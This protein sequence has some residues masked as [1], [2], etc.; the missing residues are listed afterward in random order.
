MFPA[1]TN[2]DLSHNKLRSIPGTISLLSYLSVLNVTANSELDLLPPELGL[3]DKLWNVGLRECPLRKEEEPLRSMVNDKRES[4]KTIE[5][6][7]Y[8]R[9]KLEK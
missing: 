5:I 7:M 6:L 2:L 8:L 9:N 3:L 1:L 4:Y